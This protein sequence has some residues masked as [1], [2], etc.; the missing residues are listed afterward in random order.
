MVFL[1]HQ[2]IQAMLINTDQCVGLKIFI[3][4]I[5]NLEAPLFT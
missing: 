4:C 2:V 3:K 1:C 5:S